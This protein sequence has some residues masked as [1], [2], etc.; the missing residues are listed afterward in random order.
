MSIS[1]GQGLYLGV[2]TDDLSVFIG[3]IAFESRDQGS[4]EF[5]GP[6]FSPSKITDKTKVYWKYVGKNKFQ[7]EKG[8]VDARKGNKSY[9][10]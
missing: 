1:R 4:E 5:W 10:K 2:S 6:K 8:I 9:P 3:W 7:L